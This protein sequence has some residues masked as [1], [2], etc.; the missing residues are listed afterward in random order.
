MAARTPLLQIN[1]ARQSFRYLTRKVGS[2]AVLPRR[3]GVGRFRRA[4]HSW[5]ASP[6]RGTNGLPGCPAYSGRVHLVGS[7]N[8]L[9]RL[10]A[11]SRKEGQVR[12]AY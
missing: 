9:L 1:A 10:S 12:A 8:G 11:N 4:R 2:V 5:P 3:K 6:P 7:K